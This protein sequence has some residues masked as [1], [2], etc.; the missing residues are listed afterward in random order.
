MT[1]SERT[2]HWSH[3]SFC[4]QAPIFKQS[5]DFHTV[6]E[7]RV[8]G[9]LRRPHSLA[10]CYA[11]TWVNSGPDKWDASLCWHRSWGLYHVGSTP[12]D[13]HSYS[14]DGASSQRYPHIHFRQKYLTMDLGLRRSF[15]R[16][17]VVA[18][19]LHALIWLEFLK[20]HG[21]FVDPCR[22]HFTDTTRFPVVVGYLT[23]CSTSA[24]FWSVLMKKRHF[25]ELFSEF[26]KLIRPK[27]S[28]PTVTKTWFTTL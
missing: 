7:S 5:R 19:V 4:P 22:W 3:R 11:V 13:R 28:L 2:L 16:V 15:P 25:N 17:T 9:R 23:Q 24:S 21:L 26:L 1:K 6:Q 18:G 27:N 14:M 20:S 12:T 8:V 10:H